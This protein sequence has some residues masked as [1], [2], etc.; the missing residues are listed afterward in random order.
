VVPRG[1]WS[2]TELIDGAHVEVVSAVQG[3]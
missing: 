3:G 1:S 2:E